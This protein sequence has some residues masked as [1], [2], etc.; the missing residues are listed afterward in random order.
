M[1]GD[2][3]RDDGFLTVIIC[4][5]DTDA[6]FSAAGECVLTV[7]QEKF[8]IDAVM[9]L[10]IFLMDFSKYSDLVSQRTV[11]FVILAD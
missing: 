3:N 9:V 5:R 6:L 10:G 11:K 2:G 8:L 4:C 7:C 1:N